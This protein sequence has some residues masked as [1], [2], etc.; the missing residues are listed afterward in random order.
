[1]RDD[2]KELVQQFMKTRYDF[3]AAVMAYHKPKPGGDDDALF[4]RM[5]ECERAYLAFIITQVSPGVA[6]AL[7][8]H[9]RD[10]DQLQKLA[11]MPPEGKA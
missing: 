2:D 11:A 10:I 6:A 1:M 3:A 8:R 4:D 9:E 7:T 5:N